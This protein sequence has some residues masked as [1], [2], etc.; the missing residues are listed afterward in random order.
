MISTISTSVMIFNFQTNVLVSFSTHLTICSNSLFIPT[1]I[2][3]ARIFIWKLLPKPLPGDYFSIYSRIWSLTLRIISLRSPNVASTEL[4]LLFRFF[5]GV[6]LGWIGVTLSG[7]AQSNSP[8]KSNI[9]S[10]CSKAEWN[11]NRTSHISKCTWCHLDMRDTQ[12][13]RRKKSAR[14][15]VDSFICISEINWC[16][17]KQTQTTVCRSDWLFSGNEMNA[18][19]E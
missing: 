16:K 4:F 13:K 3:R 11:G 15:R 5:C 1:A 9:T 18:R 7:A 6:Q 12:T 8:C 14:C 17:K 2:A 19:S 10:H